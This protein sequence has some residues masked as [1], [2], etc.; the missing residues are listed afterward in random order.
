MG[1]FGSQNKRN[2]S[3]KRKIRYEGIEVGGKVHTLECSTP[4]PDEQ[5]VNTKFAELVVSI[6][7]I[8]VVSWILLIT[9][10]DGK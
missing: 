7:D 6:L 1:C 5:E 3:K 2:D 4:M 9:L 10:F 8:L